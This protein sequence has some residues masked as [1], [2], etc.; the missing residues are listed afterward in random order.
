MAIL[1]RK[2]KV[3]KPKILISTPLFPPQAGGPATYSK[4]LFEYL[5]G[6]G[7]EVSLAKF[8][9]ISFLPKL[10]SHLAYFL[11]VVLKSIGAD[12]VYAQDPVSVGL[13]S[14]LA[15]RILGKRFFLK[16]VG[17][18]AWEQGVQRAGITDSLDV[19]SK[20][21]E[22]YPLL[23]A[24]LKRVQCFVASRAERV[25]VPS[26]YL[27]NIVSNWGIAE[28][29][30]V[31]IYNAAEQVKVLDSK[32][33][34]RKRFSWSGPILA[35]AGRFVP[36]KGFDGLLRVF[37]RLLES[38]REARLVLIGDGP[39]RARLESLAARLGI[40]G[41]VFFTGRLP[42]KE[43]LEH[44]QASDVFV[45]NSS[46]EGFSHQLL[47][48]LSLS[49]PTVATDAGGNAEIVEDGKSGLL[50]PPG[51]SGPLLEAILKVLENR[52]L[53][54]KLSRCGKERAKEF[55]GERMLDAITKLLFS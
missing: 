47:E 28:E 2:I 6:R 33:S 12:I 17:D 9:S 35:S 49:V 52:R 32:E 3:E 27:K 36:W 34:L 7:F 50:V 18:Y 20:R 4:I 55:G 54:A 41:K 45:L 43:A 26:R 24:V 10:L 11:L 29:R 44:I 22:G 16:I 38:Y 39:D 23:V 48:V 19:F 31:V 13:P 53:S 37:P 42:R 1:A 30:I 40:S 15:A 5:P 46:Y 14:L 8:S 21:S 25:V 51:E